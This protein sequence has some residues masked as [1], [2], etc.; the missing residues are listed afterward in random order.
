MPGSRSRLNHDCNQPAIKYCFKKQ[1][2]LNFKSCVDRISYP[3]NR[4]V[5]VTGEPP[6]LTLHLELN[7]RTVDVGRWQLQ[8][9]NAVGAGH[10]DFDVVFTDG[11]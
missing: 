2:C 1:T 9:T 8:L 3:L 5:K 7:E 10:V 6:D 11:K 4:P